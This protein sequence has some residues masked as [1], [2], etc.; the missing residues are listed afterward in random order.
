[1]FRM[2]CKSKIQRASVT[3]T[4]LFYTGSITIDAKLMREADILPFERVQIANLTNGKRLETYVIE[5]AE[6]SG[7]IC[8]NGAAAR[9]AE[10]GDL[11]LIISYALMTE[12]EAKRVAPRVVHVDSKNR[13][14]KIET[15][16]SHP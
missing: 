4:N 11:V 10:P 3:E 6:D 15:K 2:M 7:M 9:C 8:M 12:E 1:M 5:G 13:I 16:P 14:A